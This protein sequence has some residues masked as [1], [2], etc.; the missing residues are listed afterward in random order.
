[1]LDKHSNECYNIFANADRRQKI[2][3]KEKR[4]INIDTAFFCFMIGIKSKL[5]ISSQTPL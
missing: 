1:M 2:Y 4:V 3:Y 5:F